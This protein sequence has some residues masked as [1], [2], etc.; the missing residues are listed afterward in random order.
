[1]VFGGEPGAGN[2]FTTEAVANSIAG[3]ARAL[4]EGLQIAARGGVFR[5]RLT[6]YEVLQETPAGISDALANPQHGIGG[7]T[8]LF[9]PGV[10][11]L[12]SR[13]TLLLWNR[14]PD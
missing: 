11:S 12:E 1:M 14:V 9:I 4:N 2:F 13:I 6:G 8:Q 10:Q 7:F 3:N 5:P